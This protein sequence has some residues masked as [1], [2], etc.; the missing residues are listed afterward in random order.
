MGSVF[1]VTGPH[2][3]D[4]VLPTL[5]D[6]RQDW[7]GLEHKLSQ[8]ALSTQWPEVHSESTTQAAPFVFGETHWFPRQV[9]PVAHCAVVEHDVRHAIPLQM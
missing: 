8:Q 5:R 2:V 3:P 1:E 6:I 9:N 7:Q 4:G